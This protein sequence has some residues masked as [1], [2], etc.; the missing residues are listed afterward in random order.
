MNIIC[1]LRGHNWI[2]VMETGP[3]TIRF[4]TKCRRCGKID[5]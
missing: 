5:R 4:Y 3:N 1:W 2:R